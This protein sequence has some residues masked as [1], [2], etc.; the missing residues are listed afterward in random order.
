MYILCKRG[1]VASG[2]KLNAGEKHEVSDKDGRFLCNIGA[3]EPVEPQEE[4]QQGLNS[5]NT[6][7]VRK[8]R[9]AKD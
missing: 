3:A 1:T 4:K 6:G 5:R 8:A 7:T 2:A 9:K